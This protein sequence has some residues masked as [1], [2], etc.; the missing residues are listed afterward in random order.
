VLYGRR[1]GGGNS[2]RL[3]ARADRTSGRWWWWW[4]VAAARWLRGIGGLR[5]SR[6][7]GRTDE[8]DD[9]R[10]WSW[11]HGALVSGIVGACMRH[12]RSWSLASL[13]GC[14]RAVVLGPPRATPKYTCCWKLKQ[15]RILTASLLLQLTAKVIK[16]IN[17]P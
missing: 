8:D 14:V 13:H 1:A 4:T 2:V 5:L 12:W 15:V 7:Q 11:Q 9:R 10:G 3:H 16:Y 17:L 6:L